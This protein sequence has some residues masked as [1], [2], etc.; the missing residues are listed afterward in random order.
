MNVMV[1]ETTAESFIGKIEDSYTD[2]TH[3]Y[4]GGSVTAIETHDLVNGWSV[5]DVVAHI[6]AWDWRCASLIEASHD[7]NT[8][9]E[10]KPDIDA[11]NHEIHQERYTWNWEIV[12]HDFQAAHTALIEAIRHLPPERLNDATIQQNIAEET[13]EHYAEHLPDLQHWHDRISN[14]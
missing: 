11:L 7:T 4:Q 3:L 13:W 2:I 1:M 12:E 5:K 10:A 6:A 8:P 14:A 9:L